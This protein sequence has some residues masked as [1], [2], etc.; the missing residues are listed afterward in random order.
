MRDH[1]LGIWRKIVAQAVVGVLA[2]TLGL[3]PGCRTAGHAPRSLQFAQPT[4]EAVAAEVLQALATRDAG[5][6]ERLLVTRD[7]FC[8]FVWPELPSRDIP[9]LTCDWVWEAFEPMNRAKSAELMATHG[10][11]QYHLVRL[12]CAGHSSYRTF[13]V[14]EKPR[15]TIRDTS[16]REH[17]LRLFGS[18]LQ[19]GNQF[20]LLSF[21]ED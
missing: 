12:T 16:G 11:R 6:L 13:T 20:K 3:S 2:L 7:E 1:L 5:R 17:D 18:V 21:G 10:G 8:S 9:N 4:A 15:V 14:H 19:L